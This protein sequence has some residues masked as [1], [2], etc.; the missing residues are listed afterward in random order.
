MKLAEGFKR[1]RDENNF[2]LLRFGAAIAVLISHS[3]TVATGNTDAEPLRKWLGTTPGQMAVDVFFV[4]SGFLVTRSLIQRRQIGE[5]LR[6]RALRIYPALFVMVAITVLVL[7]LGLT[8]LPTSRFLSSPETMRF[9]E[10][11]A[12]LL[13]GFAPGLPG[14]FK[15]NPFEGYV[16]GSLWSMPYE[17]WM[18]LTLAGLWLCSLALE[19][20]SR[21]IFEVAAVGLF[22]VSGFECT[23]HMLGFG[24]QLPGQMEH[25]T[26]MFFTG[27]TY[28]ILRDRVSLTHTAFWT[29]ALTVL[30]SILNK[31]V[32]AVVYTFSVAY[33][34]LYLAYIPTGPIHRFNK[35]G[36]Y[37]YGIYI[38]AFPVQQTLA[39]MV[40]GISAAAMN[41]WAI[42]I[43][44][45]LAV[46]SWHLIERRALGL[47]NRLPGY[48]AQWVPTS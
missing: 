4:T 27:T 21:R 8:T 7:G 41:A 26:F 24:N 45:V 30:L 39:A 37:S 12:T 23:K 48:S 28:Y 29:I 36:D 42:P 5:F 6:A 2:N 13:T 9:I 19:K 15:N 35:L 31:T 3:F 17:L 44:L 43:T 40:P 38:Y 16:N 20:Y 18:Y 14:V 25:L 34:V 10:K 33:L 47:K 11:N 46:L 32:F 22:L 1:K